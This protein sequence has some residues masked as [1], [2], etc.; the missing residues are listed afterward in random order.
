MV[1]S[2]FEELFVAGEPVRVYVSGAAGATLRVVLFHPWWG[3][4]DDVL[5]YADRLAGAGFSVVARTWCEAAS[6][7]PSRRP[8]AWSRAWTRP[9]PTRSRWPPSI[10]SP[11]RTVLRGSDQRQLRL[12]PSAAGPFVLESCA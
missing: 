10:G 8:S 3:L 5:A 7:R 9:T 6:R 2:G 4:N 1:R 12:G 11:R